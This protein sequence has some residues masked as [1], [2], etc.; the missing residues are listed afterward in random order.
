MCKSITLLATF[1]CFNIYTQIES[2][3]EIALHSIRQITFASMGFEKAGESYFSPDGKTP[4]V[5]HARVLILDLMVKKL[6]SPPVM[7]LRILRIITAPPVINEI[8][9]TMCGSLHRT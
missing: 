9:K 7:R 3:R 2:A 8:Q 5:G 4:V 1:L 6:F